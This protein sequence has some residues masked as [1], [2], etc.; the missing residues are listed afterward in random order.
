M[1][2][3]VYDEKK[4]E[5][6]VRANADICHDLCRAT[7]RAS[8]RRG[9][10]VTFG[11]KSMIARLILFVVLCR[12]AAAAEAPTRVSSI[13][14]VALVPTEDFVTVRFT[15]EHDATWR[16]RLSKIK[17]GSWSVA[18]GPAP[19]DEIELAPFV[20][21]SGAYRK[22]LLM[23]LSDFCARSEVSGVVSHRFLPVLRALAG[24]ILNE[25]NQSPEPTAMLV[26][27]R[28][29]PRVAPSTAVAHL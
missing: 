21:Q 16:L 10:P 12:G 13:S 17:S 19:R 5:P 29:E 15:D 27:P 9:S 6:V 11:K 1:E 8:C 25:P 22:K 7:D 3:P 2:I 4:A 26:T 20:E 18:F 28:A 14:E 23:M 24:E